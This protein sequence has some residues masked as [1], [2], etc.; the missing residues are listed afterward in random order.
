MQI[1]F[2]E[3]PITAQFLRPA[4]K[5]DNLIWSKFVLLTDVEDG[6]LAWNSFTCSLAFIPDVTAEKAKSDYL[7]LDCVDELREKMF[8]V[9][10]ST[11]ELQ[12]L[13]QTK[14]MLDRISTSRY[15]FCFIFTTYACN[16][17]CPYCYE[18]QIPISSMSES[19]AHDI[20]KFLIANNDD[21]ILH[22]RW[23]GGEPM[24]NSKVIDIICNELEQNNI[25]FV[26]S[27][28]SNAYLFDEEKIEHAIEKW[29]LSWIQ[30][31]LD[32]P[33]DVYNEIKNY[34]NDNGNA[35]EHV[36]NNIQI[37]TDNKVKV[38][39]RF[40]VSNDNLNNF[41]E[42]TDVLEQ[43]FKGNKYFFA[44]PK[45]LFDYYKPHTDDDA[46]LVLSSCKTLF[47]RLESM[48][49]LMPTMLGRKPK[50]NNCLADSDNSYSIL[51]NGKFNKCHHEQPLVTIGDV[52]NGITDE[53]L[54]DAFK[55]RIAFKDKCASC[56][57]APSCVQLKKC[58]H[59]CT[60]V[61]REYHTLWLESSIKM[62]YKK[63]KSE[64]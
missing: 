50:A 51:P 17:R 38:N 19:T 23:F 28:I 40:N 3:K 13:S 30:I 10:D 64:Q 62:K 6:C 32:G 11:N 55:E 8:L 41:L 22:I 5:D 63:W 24:V 44:Y 29:R 25:P 37:F 1:I 35:F 20:A 58:A 7:S 60:D 36:L 18:S 59:K 42:L 2:N 47:D 39:V 54:N 53:E 45:F 4:S 46:R 31:T 9:S 27:M 21:K 14:M 61:H 43:R 56:V 33:Q 12:R 49:M 26:S 16:A 57:L 48:D 34:V 52:V 15:K